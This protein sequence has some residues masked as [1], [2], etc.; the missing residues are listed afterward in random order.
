MLPNVDL[1]LFCK[2]L[3]EDGARI[4]GR[5]DLLAVGHHRVPRQG[6]VMLPARQLT[7]A[8]DLAVYGAQTRT[9]TLTPDH[10][11]VVGGRDLAAPLEQGAVGIEQKLSVVH[12]SA[13]TLVHA[14]RNDDPRLLGSRPDDVRGR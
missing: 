1:R 12:S 10:T 6:V 13:V 4:H 3:A 9:V 11:L 14:D 2:Q 7:N 5:V 8:A